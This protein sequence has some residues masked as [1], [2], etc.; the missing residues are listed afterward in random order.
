MAT[1]K[2][3]S[4]W[5]AQSEGY[6]AGIQRSWTES[7]QKSADGMT[8]GKQAEQ[9]MFPIRD[10]DLLRATDDY[11]A[12]LGIFTQVSDQID[13]WE[14]NLTSLSTSLG[15]NVQ[16]WKSLIGNDPRLGTLLAAFSTQVSGLGSRIEP[17]VKVEIPRFRIKFLPSVKAELAHI[18]SLRSQA[19]R[20]QY[21][22]EQLEL[23]VTDNTLKKVIDTTKPAWLEQART[24]L[25]AAKPL[26][27]QALAEFLERFN[28]WKAGT[29]AEFEALRAK[30]T[31]RLE[32]LP[33]PDVPPAPP[34]N[35]GDLDAILTIAQKK[36]APAGAG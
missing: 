15:G 3:S 24:G 32:Q 36:K 12:A 5:E 9:T 28:G 26:F 22:V 11:F 17:L 8:I 27:F 18:D 21:K 33:P 23:A 16:S 14:K 31:E 6:F 20:L 34:I 4:D 35:Y 7:R 1:A 2:M 19:R 25:A 13:A 30:V 10:S 29:R